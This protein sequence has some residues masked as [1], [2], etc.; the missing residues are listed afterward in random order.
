MTTTDLHH[1]HIRSYVLRQGRVSAAQ[2]RAVDELLPRYGIPY[3]PQ[4]IDLDAVFGRRAPRFLEIGFGMGETTAVIAAAHPGNDYLGIEVHT[5]GV[6][7][8]LKTLGE[9]GLSNLR[10]VQHDAVEVLRD[11]LQPDGLDGIHVFFP[12]PWPKRRQAHRRLLQPDLI[13]LVADRLE[14]GGTL[15]WA[16]DDARYAADTER[17][18]LAEARFAPTLERA[19]P[20]WRPIT[21]FEQT[22][23]RA[24][25]PVHEGAA[26]THT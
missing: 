19:R 23:L 10:V 4:A 8:L 24:G 21:R 26:R 2:R 25:R 16:T 3:A 5:P 20:P 13:A 7:A 15:R 14:P 6:G 17:S 9:L 12:D 11:M 18:V 1:G 22:A